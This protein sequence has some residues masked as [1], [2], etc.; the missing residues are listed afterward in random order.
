MAA[1]MRARDLLLAVGNHLTG[2]SRHHELVERGARLVRPARTH[3]SYR[4]LARGAG[5]PF[6]PGLVE[7]GDGEGMRISG[8]LYELPTDAVRELARLV[9]DPIR[10]GRVR[11]EDGTEV[12]GYL[13]DPAAAATARDISHYGGWRDFL[14]AGPE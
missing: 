3:E 12:H 14:A 10:L 1:D 4:L 6:N 11:L 7:V 8:E 2:L 9:R 13:C 5:A